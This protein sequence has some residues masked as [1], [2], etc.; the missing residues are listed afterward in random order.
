MEKPIFIF[1]LL[2]STSLTSQNFLAN[3]SFEDINKCE[4]YGA[5]CAAEAWFRIPPYD[6]TITDKA[7][8]IPHDGKISELIVVENTF[9]P[10]ARRVYLY[11]KILCPLQEGKDYQLSFFL[12]NLNRKEYL[13]EALFSEEELIAGEK[14]PLNFKPN[15]EFTIEQ[16]MEKNLTTGWKKVQSTYQATGQEKFL[17]IGYFSKKEITAPRKEVSNKKGDIVML[18]DDIELIPLD[19]NEEICADFLSQK[20]K[21]YDQDYRHTNK[22]SVDHTPEDRSD[23]TW[24]KNFFDKPIEVDSIEKNE[25]TKVLKPIFPNRDWNEKDTLVFEVP[26][27]A[28]RF[29]DIQ[30]KK[31]FQNKLDSFALQ[32]Q[33][34]NPEKIQYLGHTDNMG[35]EDY[36]Q[37]LSK[38][39]AIAVKNYLTRYTF[40]KNIPSAVIGKGELT[41]KADNKTF[42][43]RQLNRRVEIIV[44]KNKDNFSSQ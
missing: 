40:F 32:I 25:T 23:K 20:D 22:I 36:N 26:L 7:L 30:I 8:R 10:L 44:F 11:T 35:T 13:I 43:G 12:N 17:T 16:E 2:F 1:L 3:P 31:E 5:K 38:K 24:N 18:I 19:K 4:E 37:E 14:N 41:P 33:Y 27:V 42:E 6:L 39:R 9:H 15:L 29:D 28:F 21:L 34:L